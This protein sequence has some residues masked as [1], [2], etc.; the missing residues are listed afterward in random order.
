MKKLDSLPTRSVRFFL[1]SAV[2]VIGI[3][4]TL[5]L[6][7]AVL[8]EQRVQLRRELAV[9]A[10]QMTSILETGVR[11]RILALVRVARQWEIRGRPDA[12]SWGYDSRL[13]TQHMPGIRSISWLDARAKVRW[14]E[15]DRSGIKDADPAT[16]ERRASAAQLAQERRKVIMS[17]PLTLE[18]GKTGVAVY[19]PIF[20]RDG[21]DGHLVGIFEFDTLFDAALLVSPDLV[22]S[23]SSGLEPIRPPEG[24]HL[25]DDWVQQTHLDLYGSAWQ[26]SVWPMSKFVEDRESVFPEVVLWAGL[27]VS[28][29][30]ALILQLAYEARRRARELA[31]AQQE[32]QDA[33]TALEYKVQERTQA[34][35]ETLD[36]LHKENHERKQSERDLAASE[37]RYRFLAESIPQ[38][39]WTARPDGALDYYNQRWSDYTG[40]TSEQTQSEG[41][42]PILHPDDYQRTG[43]VWDRSIATGSVFSIEYRLKR[44]NDQMY[45]WHLGRAVPF[46]DENNTIVKWFGTCTD[47]DDQKRLQMELAEAKQAAEAAAQ[48]KTNFLANISHEI[49][50]PINGIIGTTGLLLD[51]PLTPE[52]REYADIL[53]NSGESLLSV[54]NDLLDLSKIE[55]GKLSL[56]THDMDLSRTLE[57]ALLLFGEKAHLKKLELATIIDPDLPLLL[58]G[59]A[60]RLRQVLINL[61]GNAIKY[62]DHGEVVVRLR[63]A[64]EEGADLRVRI[65][66]QDTGIGLSDKQ[67]KSL[68]QPFYQA[69]SSASRAYGGTGL[70]LAIS[71]Q[72]VQMMGGKIGVDSELGKGSR[73]WIVFP[74][75]KQ[76]NQ[77]SPTLAGLRVLVVDDHPASR[78]GVVGRLKSWHADTAEA[79]S[80]Q[81]ALEM[82][83]QAAQEGK[84]F[85]CV[86]TDWQM[87]ERDGL[88]LAQEIKA[89]ARIRAA[90]VVMMASVARHLW[91]DALRSS[92]VASVISKPVLYSQLFDA[93]MALD[94][95]E[96]VTDRSQK[97][98]PRSEPRR[99]PDGRLIRV[100]LAEDNPVNQAVAVRQLERLGYACD[101]VANGQEALDVLKTETY[102]V[103]LMDLQM[104][105]M[106]GYQ[107]T[108]EIRRREKPPV[109]TCIIAMTAHALK[110]DRERCLAAGMDDYISKP[111][112]PSELAGVLERWTGGA[113]GTGA[114]TTASAPASNAQ[115]SV[116][117]EQFMATLG[118]E[119]ADTQA[120][121]QL[122]LE[123]TTHNLTELKRAVEK[124]A[125]TD[126]E[127][128][129][130]SAAGANAMVGMHVMAQHLRTLEFDAKAGK[131]ENAGAAVSAILTEFERVKDYLKKHYPSATDQAVA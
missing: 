35:Q 41:W 91:D 52:Q 5:V 74:M 81:Q 130:H 9:E 103:V 112:K 53:Y 69:D 54:V 32:L 89:D 92:A 122:Y 33:H 22:T 71:K 34:L 113:Q 100:L 127:R 51:T 37:Q 117:M 121:V 83:R 56:E 45:R 28:V 64:G 49:R 94:H 59:D 79:P 116:D 86:V 115:A 21:F 1:P 99:R 80:A 19:V 77:T 128:I 14:T 55:A 61:I 24:P 90:R 106:D 101:S 119:G 7:R 44:A 97:A 75:E 62:T 29:L 72:L 67:L 131:L 47:I 129:A 126:I 38:M 88:T 15:P 109:H 18:S 111:V 110:E 39:V 76:E 16:D 98:P 114:A 66:V 48:A 4:A 93:L 27:I 60:A 23:I 105:E 26:V 108:T 42:K 57:S 2:G 120:L 107:A 58:R 73:F 78:E 102:D 87:P 36:A 65:E 20:F 68:F 123:S 43:E 31:H 124:D 6:W 63:R 82:L 85:N 70:G 13:L 118:A 96:L 95:P 3:L 84:P 12:I 46:R 30:L 40:M 50:T 104:P 125:G 10:H 17:R 8:T 25:G 11:T